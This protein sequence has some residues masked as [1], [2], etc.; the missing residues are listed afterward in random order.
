MERRSLF[1]TS[2]LIGLGAVERGNLYRVVSRSFAP[3]RAGWF[4]FPKWSK[5]WN[6]LQIPD[7]NI[8]FS[9]F[10]FATCNM[11]LVSG[12]EEIWRYPWR[13]LVLAFCGSGRWIDWI[14]QWS[15]FVL[16]PIICVLI[17]PA[18]WQSSSPEDEVLCFYV[19]KCFM[20]RL[21]GAN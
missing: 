16:V 18:T 3:W 5:T 14:L 6:V 7:F 21:I 13:S 10:R 20:F 4:F 11:K 2:D 17:K 9:T 19:D 12:Q 1:V 15:R 8:L